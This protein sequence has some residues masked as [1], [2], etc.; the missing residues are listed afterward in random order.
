MDTGSDDLPV[1]AVFVV[2]GNK[3]ARLDQ[4]FPAARVFL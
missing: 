4:P 2:V 1:G 3:D